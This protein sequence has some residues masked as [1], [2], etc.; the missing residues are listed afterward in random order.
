MILWR[1]LDRPGHDACRLEKIESGWRLEGTAVFLDEEGPARLSYS[2]TCDEHWQSERGAVSG[3][4]GP[5]EIEVSIERMPDGWMLNGRLIAGLE[6]CVDLDFGF[7][8]ATNIFL[9]RRL[10]LHPGQFADVSVVWFDAGV[11]NLVRLP[12]RYERRTATK[13]WYESPTAGYAAELEVNANGFVLQ[14]PRLWT[15]DPQA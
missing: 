5:Q 2:V 9:L 3:W 11:D 13:Y 12:Q 15:A 8:P 6:D 1:R 7:T 4:I 14:Y 10:E